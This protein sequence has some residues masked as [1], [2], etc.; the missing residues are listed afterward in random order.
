MV[1]PNPTSVGSFTDFTELLS[2]ETSMGSVY[3]YN[4]SG[5]VS[6]Q[7]STG[8]STME[9]S[10][11]SFDRTAFLEGND[12]TS[13]RMGL[14]RGLAPT[15]SGQFR[16]LDYDQSKL[17]RKKFNNLR[18]NNKMSFD[19]AYRNSGGIISERLITPESQPRMGYSPLEY[20]LGDRKFHAGNEVTKITRKD[21]S[22]NNFI[23]LVK[24]NK[25]GLTT[26]LSK[27]RID[28]AA[29]TNI[30]AEHLGFNKAP[31][32]SI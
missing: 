26:A 18:N 22:V 17:D 13:A 3:T 14:E 2:F 24:N 7:K 30:F 12:L 28:H 5:R 4:S 1:N 25:E 10:S 11:S 23:N 9:A 6:R 19:E 8:G 16:G 15:E 31:R 27:E 32:Q 29:I 20:N 21:S